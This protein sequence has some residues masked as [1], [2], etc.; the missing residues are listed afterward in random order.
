[1][2]VV[3]WFA[4]SLFSLVAACAHN[5]IPTTN[6]DDTEENRQ[7]LDLVRNYHR[8]VESRDAEAVLAMVSKRFYEDNGNTDR[9]D[10]YDYEQLRQSL[11]QD[12]ERTKA[13]QLEIRV[14]EIV[15][16]D[17]EQIAHA[18]IYYTVRGHAQFPTGT[19]WKT[20]TDRARLT[21]TREGDQ[22]KI[23]SGL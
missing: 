21:F 20:S 16:E 6:I 1:M 13:M 10:D 18:F 23:I 5:K 8:A 19:K 9:T 17:E 7:I 3:R 12:F 4:V 2:S 15:V 22:W 11:P 14:D